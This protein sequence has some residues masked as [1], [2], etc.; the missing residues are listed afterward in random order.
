MVTS[1]TVACHKYDATRYE[2]ILQRSARN[3]DYKGIGEQFADH[4]NAPF[5][6]VH[7]T[8]TSSSA[9]YDIKLRLN[10]RINKRVN[11]FK[12][13]SKDQKQLHSH[14]LNPFNELFMVSDISFNYG[15]IDLVKFEPDVNFLKVIVRNRMPRPI[16]W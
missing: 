15:E 3:N 7:Y 14:K 10:D 13:D 12:T 11:V 4:D 1:H 9:H 5:K 2:V 6:F 8:E 16:H